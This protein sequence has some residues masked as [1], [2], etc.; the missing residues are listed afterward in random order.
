MSGTPSLY[1]TLRRYL[2]RYPL[3]SALFVLFT[4]LFATMVVAVRFAQYSAAEERQSARQAGTAFANQIEL[5]LRAGLSVTRSLTLLVEHG[6]M[7]ARFD[8]IAARIIAAHPML[9]AIELAPGGIVTQVFPPEPNRAALGFNILTDPVQR[10]EAERAER[11]RRPVFAGPLRLVQG[12]IGVVGRHPVYLR[13]EGE[14]RFWGFTIVIITVDR[15]LRIAEIDDLLAKGYAVQLRRYPGPAPETFYNME[16]S[17]DEPETVPVNVPNGQWE[18]LIA[19]ASGWQ[20]NRVPG[21]TVALGTVL[22]FVLGLFFWY[23]GRQPQKLARLVD[24]RTAEIRNSE[25]SY[26]GLF[27]S[28]RD[29]IYLQDPEGRFIDVNDGAVAM[30]GYERNDFIGRTPE[31]LS[32]PGRNDAVDLPAIIR[33]VMDGAPQQFE[34]WGRRKDG[35]VFPKEVRLFRVSYAGAPAI[36]AIAQDVT[37]RRRIEDDIRTSNAFLRSLVHSQTN[38]LIRTDTGGRYTFVNDR[39]CSALGKERSALIGLDAWSMVV[40]ED[41]TAIADATHRC[42]AV[43]GI[44]VPV[45]LRTRTAGG[46]VTVTQWEF[47]AVTGQGGVPAGFQCVGH[48]ITEQEMA[49]NALRRSEQYNRSLLDTSPNATTVTDLTGTIVYANRQALE[50]YGHGAS[51]SVVG[52]KMTEWVPAD[53]LA[54]VGRL[55]DAVVSGEVLRNVPLELRRKDDTRFSA[56]VNASMVP[57]PDGRPAYILIITADVTRKKAAEDEIRRNQGRLKRAEDVAMV[58][59]WEFALGDEIMHASD[60]ARRVYGVRETELPLSVVQTM[61]LPEYRPML[62]AALKDLILGTAPY[63]VE[64]KVRRADDGRIVDIYS[65]A[66]FDPATRTVFGIIQDVTERK[67]ADERLRQ[68]EERNRALVESLPDILFVHDREGRFVDY[69]APDPGSLLMPPEEFLGRRYDEVLPPWLTDIVR[70]KFAESLNGGV[71]QYE[72]STPSASGTRYYEARMLAFGSDRVLN[73]IRDVTDRVAAQIELQRMNAELERKVEERTR[74][75][76]GTN[77]ELEAFVYSVSHDLRA[78]L[79]AIDSVTAT[80]LEDHGGGLR[81]EAHRRLGAVR[82][83]VQKMAKYLEALLTLSRVGG[84][85]LRAVRV[86]MDGIVRQTAEDCIPAGDRC[87]VTILPL[88]PAY[89]DEVMIRL[90]WTN[91]VSNA[92]KYSARVERPAIEIGGRVE[93]GR[94]VYWVRDNGVGFDPKSADKLFGVFQRLHAETDFTGTG[95]GL[96][97]VKRI[98]NRHG[99]TVTGEGEV[100]KGAVFTFTLPLSDGTSA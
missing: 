65:K 44:V 22:S 2:E 32:A 55:V 63:E 66:E 49:E 94:A 86:D 31:F 37:E 54:E 95:I 69:H 26:R 71:V 82:S 46:G 78:P 17:L 19:P 83:N 1:R 91:L 87:A 53:A 11:E 33:R 15:L 52:R 36:V 89:A 9:D 39:Y 77:Q 3:L 43:P 27:N 100:G 13:R 10:L 64:F 12:G 76:T 96:S 80:F 25:E 48:D 51:E 61:P 73:I 97:I 18:L 74:Q 57:G 79:R 98:M 84:H 50:M 6:A 59:N 47:L 34:F 20:R 68:S 56:E 70:P 38:Y 45:K 99:G 92:V 24:A 23:V 60:G 88:P 58:G 21:V 16:A 72:Y 5:T 35:S 62:D 81:P 67:K 28:V 40:P 7:P 41:M 4:L 29:A 8:S 90:V 30:Y 42:A 93:E 75:L 14:E 85:E